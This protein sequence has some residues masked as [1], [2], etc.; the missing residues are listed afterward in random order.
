M[1]VRA[2]RYWELCSLILR[3]KHSSFL[4][5]WFCGKPGT[6]WRHGSLKPIFQIATRN[7]GNRIQKW[8]YVSPNWG[9][10]G[11]I[12][13]HHCRSETSE[14]YHFERVK[15]AQHLLFSLYSGWQN[16]SFTEVARLI[17]TNIMPPISK[18]KNSG[19]RDELLAKPQGKSCYFDREQF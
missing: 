1:R 11:K 7:P 17:R 6:E 14:K 18:N 13:L 19:R 4:P 9:T 5:H 16:L 12:G 15:R 2:V 8:A 10:C 3:N